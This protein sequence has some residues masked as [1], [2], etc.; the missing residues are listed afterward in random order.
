MFEPFVREKV[1]NLR[2]LKWTNS[3]TLL[4]T[5]CTHKCAILAFFPSLLFRANHLCGT[6][7]GMFPF[8]AQNPMICSHYF[9]YNIISWYMDLYDLS[10]CT[11]LDIINIDHL[12]QLCICFLLTSATVCILAMS[13]LD[14]EIQ[15]VLKV[16]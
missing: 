1:P 11:L 4:H 2:R 9:I 15:N 5:T 10:H 8:N 3:T 7:L 13:I 12:H 6:E 16:L 14:F